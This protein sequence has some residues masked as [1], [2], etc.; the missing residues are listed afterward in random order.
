MSTATVSALAILLA[1]GLDLWR[2]EPPARFH[3]V[4]WMGQYLERAG[5]LIA[6]VFITVR[7]P[8]DVHAYSARRQFLAGE[9]AWL[10]G[11]MVCTLAA[12]LLQWGIFQLPGWMAAPLLALCLKPLFAWAMLRDLVARTE[13]ALQQGLDAGRSQLAHLV[14]RNVHELDAAGVRESAIETLAENL[15]DSLV[16]PLF[17]FVLFGLPG[18]ALYRFAN[19]A[20][21]MWGYPGERGGRWWQWAGKWA[22]RADDVLNWLP[23]RLTAALLMLGAPAALWRRLPTEARRTPSPNSGWPMSAMALRLGITLG[24]PGVYRLND[25]APQPAGGHTP[26]A[27]R[28]AQR[29]A[30]MA[31]L[32]GMLALVLQSMT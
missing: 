31:V 30:W 24:K 18:A 29:V 15:G 6:P 9:V 26:W 32:L 13:T 5:R 16:A 22:A 23:A 4:V 21:A 2:G 8:G 3:P 17:W 25:V 1:F 28:K 10:L 7:N 11:A 20:D 19:T 14:S 27:I 12:S